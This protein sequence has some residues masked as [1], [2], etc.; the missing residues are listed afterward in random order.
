MK[1]LALLTLIALT[2]VV[3]AAAEEP[4][5]IVATDDFDNGV[6]R[7][8]PLSSEWKLVENG[9]GQAMRMT[10]KSEHKPP[11]YS[12]H[13]I[14]LLKEQIVGDFDL[15]VEVKST[16]GNYEHRDVCLFF[17]FQDPGHFY[18]VHFGKNADP[19]SC[20]VMIVNDKPRTKITKVEAKGTPW[21]DGWHKIRI[22]RRVAEGTIEAYFDDMEKP[23]MTA[24]DTTFTWGQV[25][26]GTFDDSGNWDNFELRGVTV[27]K[28][29]DEG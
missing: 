11:H 13:V 6:D 15:T 22:R 10:G 8:N 14:S 26:L 21:T 12:P 5:S 3:P 20:Q 19:N 25:G 9:E 7:W 23:L 29:N 1:R 27:E 18:Y 16:G 28:D 17:G 24:V 4:L 2:L